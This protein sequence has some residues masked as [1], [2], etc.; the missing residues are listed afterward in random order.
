MSP[1]FSSSDDSQSDFAA[2]L[3]QSFEDLGD[4]Q[5]GDLL[6]GTIVAVDEYGIIVDV[7]LKR[8]GVVP[9]QDVDMLG[10]GFCCDVGQEVTVMVL[11]PED[12]DGNLVVSIQQ[13]LAT[14]D[15]DDAE[16]LLDSGDVHYGRV[17]AANKGGLIVPFG[18]LRGFVPASHVV[19]LPRGL[20]DDS[21]IQHLSHLVGQEMALKVIEVNPRRR[22]LVFSQRLAQ[23]ESRESAKGRLLERLHE[24][25]VVKGRVS[26]LRDFGAF[27]DLGG[28][29]GLIHVSE[30]AWQRVN[31]PGE[32]VRVGQEIEVYVLQLD[33]EQQRIGLS[34]KRLRSNPWLEIEQD[35]H[36]GEMVD[37][38]VSRVVSFGAFVELANGIEALLH[39]S[40][41]GNIHT[42]ELDT[43]LQPGQ[44]I[45]ARIISLEPHRQRMGLSLTGLDD[46]EPG[47]PVAST[48]NRPSPHHA[49]SA[50]DDTAELAAEVDT[51]GS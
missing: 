8:D 36:V 23:R 31:H 43:V 40:E 9:R 30:L 32:I 33:K 24:G 51:V 37:G 3:E 22:R 20:N 41:M 29:D 42:R 11:N 25:D 48:T 39:V 45:R 7:G 18:E 38:I 15:W 50:D 19:D 47:E 10:E 35:H 26:S 13:A 21:R 46:D 17:V 34:L 2:L 49:A 27:V 16:A 5:R 12:R 44:S 1:A 14:G 28:A 6:D 4:I